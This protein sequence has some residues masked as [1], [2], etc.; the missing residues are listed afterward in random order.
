MPTVPTPLS[1]VAVM[2]EK[3]A[4]KYVVSPSLIVG[5]PTKKDEMDAGCGADVVVVVVVV[6]PVGTVVVVVVPAAGITVTVT[7]AVVV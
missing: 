1:T 4:H 6:D 2:P 7:V 5:V 3:Y